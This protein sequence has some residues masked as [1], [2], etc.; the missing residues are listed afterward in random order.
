M[1]SIGRIESEVRNFASLIDNREGKEQ[2]IKDNFDELIGCTQEQ[3]DEMVSL[4]RTYVDAG[5]SIKEYDKEIAQCTKNMD[6]LQES[7]R[8]LEENLKNVT[9]QRDHDKVEAEIAKKEGQ[10]TD[11]Q[12]QTKILK[13]ER[14]RER[15]IQNKAARKLNRKNVDPAKAKKALGKMDKASAANAKGGLL[16]SIGKFMKNP[17]VKIITE[18]VKALTSIIEF[19]ISKTTEYVRLDT[20]NMLRQISAAST[21]NANTLRVGLE[22]WQNAV[23]GAYTATEAAAENQLALTEAQNATALAN[24]KMA[25]SW[26]NWIPI[27][28]KLNEL[29]EAKLEQEQKLQEASMRMAKDQLALYHQ[30]FKRIDK[31]DETE[32][33]AVHLFQVERG[34]S[35]EQTDTFGKRMFNLGPEFAKFGKTITDALK[36]QSSYTEQ[37]GRSVNFSNMDYEK[38]FAVGRLVGEDNLMNFEAQMNLFNVSVSDAADI[39][40]DMYKDV[41]RMGLSQKKVTKDVLGNLKL[42]QKYDFKNGTKGFMEL[43]KWAENARFNLGSLGGALEK[44]QSGGFENTITTS[45]KLQVLGGPFAM[46]SDPLGMEFEANAAPEAYAKRIQ[47]MFSTMG[48]F[49]RETGQTTFN[50]AENKTIRSAAEAL[51]ISVEDAKNMAR[52][53]RQKDY[54]KRQMRYS[55]LNPEDQ[56]AIANKAQYDKKTGQWYVN[57]I[58]GNRMNVGDVKAQDLDRILSGNREEDAQKYAQSTLSVVEQ[59]EATTK[60]INAQLGILSYDKYKEMSEK[61]REATLKGMTKMQNDLVKKYGL[62]KEYGVKKLDE[63][64]EK[65]S[66]ESVEDFKKWMELREGKNVDDLEN[67]QVFKFR[68][69][70]HTNDDLKYLASNPES[71]KMLSDDEIRKLFNMTNAGEWVLGE[72]ESDSF[73]KAVELY[74]RESR[75]Q[76]SNAA[77]SAP[78]DENSAMK[79]SAPVKVIVNDDWTPVRTEDS[80]VSGNGRPMMVSASDVTPIQDGAVKLAKSDPK[81]S[82]IFAKTGG[83]FDKLFDD[84][85]GKVNAIYDMQRNGFAATTNNRYGGDVVSSMLENHYNNA[86]TSNRYDRLGML[87]DSMRDNRAHAK[88]MSAIGATNTRNGERQFSYS[89]FKMMNSVAKAMGVSV[90]DIRNG[91]IPGGNAEPR[92]Y[93]KGFRMPSMTSIRELARISTNTDN[94]NNV[95]RSAYNNSVSNVHDRESIVNNRYS[96]VKSTSPSEVS[97]TINGK[98]ELAGQNGETINIIEQL[99]QNPMFVRQITE[100]IAIQM[101]NNTYGGR[102]E[103]FPG[104]FSHT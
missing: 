37:S 11:L 34:L 84:I 64:Y 78:T 61:E 48:R 40:Y 44:I 20:E 4:T 8:K 69:G 1:S 50:Y 42:A 18:V 55:T 76:T 68:Y 24:L 22:T 81:D 97:L 101:N 79:Y 57:T 74:S 15:V 28:G 60:Q 21:V 91:F 66:E 65:M 100:M 89:E 12:N 31:Y 80:I 39:M 56:D 90:D 73:K 2:A 104:R 10:L 63:N 99:R 19:G 98:L 85:F 70:L 32:D 71:R 17:Y 35:S 49:D 67:S 54:V 36:M 30:Y 53:A 7:L 83:P 41:N 45:A 82:A 16:G 92:P 3:H 25:H 93:N 77:Y 102:N 59:I 94:Y 103:L 58:D 52:G 62:E 6:K 47:K 95:V 87:Y 13:K 86:T 51:G 23:E 46:L 43:A 27:R 33:K 72:G 14:E 5:E 88:R 96:E 26:T 38:N 29:E 9:N 75:K